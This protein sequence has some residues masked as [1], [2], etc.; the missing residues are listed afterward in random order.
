MRRLRISAR[1]TSIMDAEFG[2]GA[3]QRRAWMH[4]KR[5]AMAPESMALL[6]PFVGPDA[7][8]MEAYSDEAIAALVGP[9]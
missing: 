6:T 8:P 5:R 1:L 4:R 7:L 9:A 3:R 2:D